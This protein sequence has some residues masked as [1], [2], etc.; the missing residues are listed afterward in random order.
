[1]REINGAVQCTEM[2]I[3]MDSKMEYFPDGTQIDSWF[4]DTRVPELTELGT[5][6]ILTD[7]GICDDGK[8]YTEEI[9]KLIH[10][11]AENGGGVLV[12][13]RGTYRTGALTFEQ[14][15]NLY[16]AEGGVLKGSEDITDYPICMTRIE[17]ETC[18][19]FM[20]LI[21]ADGV[22]GFTMCGPGTIDGNGL[23]SWKSFWLRREW[24]PK[25]T[26]KDEQR[27]RLLYLSHCSNVLVAGLHLENSHF[28]TTHLY[29][30]N[31]VK[32]I[33]CHIFSPAKPVKAPSTD[34]IDI[35]VCTD[36]LVKN[37]YLEV[38]D[39]AVVLKGGKGPWADEAPENGSNERI[40]VEDCTYGF[41]HGCLTLG[42][43]SVHN[44]SV[45]LRR[46]KVSE[47]SNLLW[48][49]MRPDTPQHY[50]YILVEDI[51]GTIK[52]FLNIN[53]WTQ[54]FDLKGRTDMPISVAEH[55]QMR[56]CKCKCEICFKVVA[57][58]KQ[59]HLSDF[60]FENIDVE[61]ENMWCDNASAKP[62]HI[63]NSISNN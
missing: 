63:D 17:G 37:C 41:C 26:N 62:F 51:E 18:L 32:Y 34:A 16:V 57:D 49:K 50:E 38:N 2:R 30:C 42:S 52:N 61:A 24:N 3:T 25:C 36:I 45:I 54:F 8:L 39:D 6:Y 47:A 10:T 27:P 55:I 31:H 1:M 58:E 9:Q 21:N 20:A 19:Y 15:V 44:R 46:I 5:Q 23:K 28:W 33:G 53:P 29:Q 60:S 43:E 48:L 40:I 14:G 7:Y 22:D 11:A 59:Y 56:N 12:V 13:P 4:Y 35:D